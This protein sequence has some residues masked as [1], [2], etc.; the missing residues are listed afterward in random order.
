MKP[1]FSL[2]MQLFYRIDDGFP[3]GRMYGVHAHSQSTYCVHAHGLSTYYVHTQPKHLLCACSSLST[4]CVHT[5]PEHLLYVCSLSEHL[6]YA[7]T[8]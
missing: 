4:Y 7:C 8:A 1:R 6:H 3:E 5:Q 2:N